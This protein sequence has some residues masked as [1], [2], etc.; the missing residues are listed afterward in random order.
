MAHALC[1][2]AWEMILVPLRITHGEQITNARGQVRKYFHDAMGRITGYVGAED[3]ISYTYD[4][5]GNVL[6]VTDQNGTICREYDA[7]NR[8]T[9]YTNTFGNVIRYEYDA[10]GNL[11]RMIY[12]DN[13]AV[14][15][16]YDANNNLASV[17][18]DWAGRTTTYTQNPVGRENMQRTI[19][20]Y[21]RKTDD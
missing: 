12:P 1:F 11:S 13:T 2:S 5:N 20:R 9:K 8:V 14:T 3:S 16:T 19:D 10:V 4:A 17:T 7:L 15:Y 6:T 21:W 18:A